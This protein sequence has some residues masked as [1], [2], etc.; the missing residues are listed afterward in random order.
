MAAGVEALH[1]LLQD[2][3]PDFH[4]AA[5]AAAAA[6]DPFSCSGVDVYTAMAAGVGAL[7][8]PLHGGASEAVLS[9]LQAIGGP[10]NVP[11]FLQQVCYNHC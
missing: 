5:A 10:D 2:R 3:A 6:L 11:Q 8:G 7:H 4:A 1:G 9:M